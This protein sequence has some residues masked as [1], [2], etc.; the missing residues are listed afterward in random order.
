MNSNWITSFPKKLDFNITCANVTYSCKMSFRPMNTFYSSYLGCF[1]Y[2]Y[3]QNMGDN[4]LML[5]NNNSLPKHPKE[6]IVI[7]VFINIKRRNVYLV[8]VHTLLD[9]GISYLYNALL[10]WIDKRLPNKYFDCHNALCIIITNT[11]F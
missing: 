10:L 2:F 8:G 11:I 7:S 4:K 6:I 9:Y 5:C 1:L 3:K